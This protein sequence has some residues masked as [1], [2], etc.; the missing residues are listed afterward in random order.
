MTITFYIAEAGLRHSNRSFRASNAAQANK[1]ASLTQ[2][3]GK[4]RSCCP[5]PPI[6][7]PQQLTA[8]QRLTQSIRG[9]AS[10]HPS[11]TG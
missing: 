7:L 5:N 1:A 6:L 3:S 9:E 2:T 11:N 4:M 8:H 10:W